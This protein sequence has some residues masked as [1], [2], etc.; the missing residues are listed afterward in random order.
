MTICIYSIAPYLL[1]SCL[2][3]RFCVLCTKWYIHH[4]LLI[5]HHQHFGTT[6]P[7]EPQSTVIILGTVNFMSQVNPSLEADY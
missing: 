1:A 2:I 5:Y 4:N 6:L 7:L 3:I